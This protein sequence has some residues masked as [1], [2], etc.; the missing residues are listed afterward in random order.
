MAVSDEDLRQ[1]Q[2]KIA[3]L[4]KQIASQEAKASTAVQE[5]SASV[6][7]ARLDTEIARLEAQLSAARE[8]AKVSNIRSGNEGLQSTL[9]AAKEAAGAKT[10]PGVTVDTNAEKQPKDTGATVPVNEKKE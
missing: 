7:A 2:E 8:S 1:K 10:P 3:N 6:E 5:E 9:K 4:R